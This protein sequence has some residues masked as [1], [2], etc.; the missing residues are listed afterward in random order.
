MAAR[1][2]ETGRAVSFVRLLGILVSIAAVPAPGIAATSLLA[3]DQ[4]RLRT[5]YRQVPLSFEPNQGQS[6]GPAQFL[7]RGPGYSIFLTPSGAVLAL[8]RPRPAA[9]GC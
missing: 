2:L 1:N 3:Q 5:V 8:A 9:S 4:H 6:A 7:S